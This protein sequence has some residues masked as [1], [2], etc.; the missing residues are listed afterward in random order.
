MNPISIFCPVTE[1]IRRHRH[2]NQL[3]D[4][5]R[6]AAM[7]GCGFAVRIAA[8]STRCRCAKGYLARSEA[9][10]ELDGGRPPENPKLESLLARLPRG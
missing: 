2:R 6:P 4:I 9:G 10:A 5:L 7:H 1:P 3:V 8:A